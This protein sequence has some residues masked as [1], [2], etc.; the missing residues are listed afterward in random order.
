MKRQKNIV[1]R[2]VGFAHWFVEFKIYSNPL[3]QNRFQ[4]K[5]KLV[6]ENSGHE[7]MEVARSG[8]EL[9]ICT[10]NFRFHP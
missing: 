3:H 5:F 1:F 7:R 2:S 9:L 6:R 8:Y 10:Y 4:N